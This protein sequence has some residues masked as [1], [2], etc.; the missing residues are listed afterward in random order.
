MRRAVDAELGRPGGAERSR[1][2][3]P[4]WP[5]EAGGLLRKGRGGGRVLGDRAGRWAAGRWAKR[6]LRAEG[7]VSGES[8]QPCQRWPLE[9]VP[10]GSRP[11][12]HYH[13]R[14]GAFPGCGHS[15]FVGASSPNPTFFFFFF[16]WLHSLLDNA[17]PRILVADLFFLWHFPG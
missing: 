16:S 4:T 1:G 14:E 8:S 12:S 11:C 2:R 17:A 13:A 10:G 5:A 7:A 6:D 9:G 3:P 15:C